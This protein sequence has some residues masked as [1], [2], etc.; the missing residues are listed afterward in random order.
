MGKR[1]KF[2]QE[3]LFPFHNPLKEEFSNEFF[4]TIPEQPGIYIMKDKEGNILY[5]GK[6]KNLQQRLRSYRYAQP[7]SISK[8]VLK[9]ISQVR[10]ISWE[11]LKS[12]KEALLRENNLLR[13]HRPEY[14]HVNTRPETYYYV[15]FS[16]KKNNLTLSL[17]MVEK[18]LGSNDVYGCF[19]GFGR[20]YRGLGS[21]MRI[22]WMLNHL[23]QDIMQIPMKLMQR[24]PPEH[25]TFS[26]AEYLKKK[27]KKRFT[28]LIKRYLKGTSDLLI[29]ETGRMIK[30]SIETD[31]HFIKKLIE[32]DLNELEDF[33]RKGPNTNYKMHRFFDLPSHIIAQDKLDDLLV[34]YLHRKN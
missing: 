4:Q 23:D 29:H 16:Q 31:N 11:P 2:K 17:T 20:V 6:S 33:Y 15:I 27:N 25:F 7:T 9:I 5:V 26:Y 34:S 28:Y 13:K 18:S 19:K 14:N 32:I 1:Q 22:L 10:E 21:L 8:K 24:K 3:N 30:D 12:E